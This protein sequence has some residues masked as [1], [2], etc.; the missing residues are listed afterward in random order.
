MATASARVTITLELDVTGGGWGHEC[1]IAQVHKQ[2]LDG[3][4]N[5][6]AEII[7]GQHGVKLV[8]EMK[9]NVLTF[10]LEEK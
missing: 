1:T 6:V 4:R 5:R 9:V 7:K 8:G 3:A 10:P 2:A